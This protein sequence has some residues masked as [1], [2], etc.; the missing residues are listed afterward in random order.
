MENGV[1]LDLIKKKLSWTSTK[2]PDKWLTELGW[3]QKKF[4]LIVNGKQN[5]KLKE[6]YKLAKLIG[7][8]TEELVSYAVE[9]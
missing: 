2:A 7:C 5:I 3:S 1:I 4:Y 8:E 9:Q 6:A